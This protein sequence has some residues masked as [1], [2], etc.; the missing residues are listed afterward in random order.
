MKVK[1]DGSIGKAVADYCGDQIDSVDVYP[2]PNVPGV[3]A[4]RATVNY[5]GGGLT[6]FVDFL[7]RVPV[8]KVTANDLEECEFTTWP[9][10]ELN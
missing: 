8:Q 2:D 4:V 6:T 9:P 7:V 3:F 5:H 1:L 10:T